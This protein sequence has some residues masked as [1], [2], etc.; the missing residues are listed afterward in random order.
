MPIRIRFVTGLMAIILA[1]AGLLLASDLSGAS[2]QLTTPT[3]TLPAPT[4]A[5][6]D[7][8]ATIDA[9]QQVIESL[10][11]TVTAQSMT[12]SAMPLPTIDPALLP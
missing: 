4:L 5:P 11:A 1:G 8:Q 6:A 3:P 10:Q 2:A 7:Y 12:L 9:Q